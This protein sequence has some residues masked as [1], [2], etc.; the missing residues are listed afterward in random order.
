M[1][2][3]KAFL[4]SICFRPIELTSCKIDEAGRAVPEKCYAQML[5]RTV[6]EERPKKR[7]PFS[8]TIRRVG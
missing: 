4:C 5:L 8:G 1:S 7:P 2:G 6:I 3:E